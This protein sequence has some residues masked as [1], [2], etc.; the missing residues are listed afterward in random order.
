VPNVHVSADE[1]S[2]LVLSEVCLRLAN[3]RV[4]GEELLAACSYGRPVAGELVELLAL[5]GEGP[6]AYLRDADVER[7]GLA[8]LR[9][10]AL[11]NLLR[12]P[13]ARHTVIDWPYDT[14][15]HELWHPVWPHTASKVLV[16]RD[17]LR[18]VLGR[19]DFPHGVLVVVPTPQE[20]VFLPIEVCQAF[21][22]LGALAA[23]AAGP[24]GGGEALGQ[25]V[26]WWHDGVLRTVLAQ[27]EGGDALAPGFTAMMLRVAEEERDRE[28]G[29]R[30]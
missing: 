5:P 27:G 22:A 25:E 4:V 26:L 17:V 1:S 12:A 7:H 15:L 29:A 9:E 20:L 3:R 19:D 28:L 23:Y 30:S 2:E 18:R 13:L 10:A 8:E 24:F 14:R 16:L 21:G 11:E 6:A